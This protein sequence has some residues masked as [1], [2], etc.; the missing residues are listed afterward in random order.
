MHYIPKNC[1]ILFTNTYICKYL[2]TLNAHIF[3]FHWMTFLCH[4]IN[5]EK[6]FNAIEWP[7]VLQENLMYLM[8][9]LTKDITFCK[10]CETITFFCKGMAF[11]TFWY[12]FL[13]HW[14]CYYYGKSNHNA[15]ISAN[16][17][18]IVL[19]AAS[20]FHYWW[21]DSGQEFFFYYFRERA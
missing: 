9:S 19:L 20:K 12:F 2:Y 10:N 5:E 13:G 3:L 14:Y 18:R 17:G 11:T 8:T 16:V 4:I 7:L 6:K 15:D 1:K 21:F